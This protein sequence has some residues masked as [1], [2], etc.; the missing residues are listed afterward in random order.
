MLKGSLA[1]NRRPQ[2]MYTFK[3]QISY[4]APVKG[5]SRSAFG[6]I[7]IRYDAPSR[8]CALLLGAAYLTKIDPQAVI[9]SISATIVVGN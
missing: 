2:V 4:H 7:T 8:G 5:S 9:D 6:C 1:P 3:V